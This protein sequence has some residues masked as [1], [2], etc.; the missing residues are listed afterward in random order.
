MM[1]RRSS[2]S[3]LADSAAEPDGVAEHDHE[4]AARDECRSGLMPM[5]GAA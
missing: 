3:S 4:L 5:G 2:G 1:I